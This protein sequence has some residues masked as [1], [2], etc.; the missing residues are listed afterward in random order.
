MQVATGTVRDGKIVVEGV[1]LREGS[2]VTLVARGADEG[3]AL[4]Q[5][6]EDELLKSLAEIDC[7]EYV[8]LDDL[9]ESLPGQRAACR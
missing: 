1:P 3:F 6:Q 2:L 7:G 8:S 5:S 4:T 9:L